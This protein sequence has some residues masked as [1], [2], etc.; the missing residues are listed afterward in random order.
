[1]IGRWPLR[2]RLTAAF[3]VMMALVLAGVAV[4]TVAHSK[5][6][7]DDSIN[8]SLGYR[9]HDLQTAAASPAGAVVSSGSADT[10][11]QILDRD[12]AIIRTS[13]EVAGQPL[14]SPAELAAARAGQIVVDHP[15]AQRVD[16][17]VRVTAAPV[18]NTGRIAVVVVSLADRDTAV[19]DLRRELEIA[20]PLVLLA[21]AVGAYLLTAAA[22]R[23][24]ERMRARAAAITADDP[25]RQLPVPR[26]DDEIARLGRTLNDMLARLHAAV[27][28][29]RQ[30]VADAGHELRTPL[31]L[32]TTELELALN[33]PRAVGEL[34]AAVASALEE[35]ERLTRLAE[36][37]L[38]LA[39]ADHRFARPTA[40][41]V[42]PLL[43][44]VASRYRIT[45]PDRTVTVEYPSGL[46]AHAGADDLHRMVSNLL[47]NALR[48]GRGPV[49][50]TARG[51]DERVVIEVRD[52]G[53]GFPPDFLPHAFGRFT[54][55]DV[56]RTGGGSGLGLAITATLAVRYG[57]QVA[58]ANHT[59]GGAVLTVTLPREPGR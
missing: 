23:P 55:A 9:L 8:E 48:H 31:S 37:L 17:P 45:A 5:S 21:A 25:G 42:G 56:A 3:T 27:S 10:A 34:T 24:V 32:V 2:I 41:E 50:V 20:F 35:T 18:A 47:D 36:D 53:P 28:R 7:L 52:R 16:S 46:L 12:G 26:A 15:H 11:A 6:T 14:L 33:R 39:R 19:G 22:L 43:D 40:V 44:A 51:A 54:R 13:D 58:A 4:A 30:F 59:G 38:L 1:M 57:G 49:A 29:E